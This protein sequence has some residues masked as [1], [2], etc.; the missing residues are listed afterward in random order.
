MTVMNKLRFMCRDVFEKRPDGRQPC[1]AAAHTVAT[2]RL[3][4]AQE[5]TNEVCIKVLE[6]QVVGV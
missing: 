6:R 3:N 1:V 4:E 2:H 5:A